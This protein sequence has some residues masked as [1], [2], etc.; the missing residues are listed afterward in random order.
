MNDRQQRSDTWGQR[1]R[2]E[3]FHRASQQEE[4]SSTKASEH[5]SKSF[6][7]TTALFPSSRLENDRLHTKRLKIAKWLKAV[8]FFF[9]FSQL[10]STESFSETAAVVLWAEQSRQGLENQEGKVA[11]QERAQRKPQFSQTGYI[12]IWIICLWKISLFP[13]FKEEQL[14]LVHQ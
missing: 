7:T 13:P 5:F 4:P 10:L 11:M 1:R 8:F 9:T 6:S 2:G 14:L 3:R 12:V